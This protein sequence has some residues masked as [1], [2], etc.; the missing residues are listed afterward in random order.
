MTPPVRVGLIIGQLSDGGSERQLFQLA[1]GLKGRSCD[2]FVYCLSEL[3][4]PY[5]PRL[6]AERIPLRILPRRRRVEIRRITTLARRL[7]EDRID[8]VNSFSQHMNFYACLAA[9]VARRGVFIASNRYLDA[10]DSPL[11]RRVNSFVYRRGRWVVVNSA[12]G[13]GFLVD[14][15]GVRRDRIEVIPNG[16][17]PSRFQGAPPP[18]ETRRGLGIPADAPLAGIVGRI[19][20]QKRVDVFLEAARRTVAAIPQ[21][22]FLIVGGGDQLDEMKMMAERTLPGKVVFTGSTPQVEAL[23]A[24]LDLLVMTSDFEGLPNAVLEA[25]AAGRPVVATDVGACRELVTEGISGFLAPPRDPEAISA[26]MIRCLSLP[27]RGRSL[28]AAGR[29]RILREFT[30]EGMIRRFEALYLRA[31]GRHVQPLDGVPSLS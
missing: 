9:L 11:V 19:S 30:L 27:D 2:P 3:I 1:R 10:R 22:R 4:E 12:E 25:M 8:V 13:A 15:Y 20:M 23:I 7:R 6:E 26:R 14:H 24:A 18:A 16:I 28:G 29:D 5:G 21:T 31:A 17:D